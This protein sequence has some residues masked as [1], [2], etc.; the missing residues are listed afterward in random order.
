MVNFLLLGSESGYIKGVGLQSH[1]QIF[2]Y[3]CESAANCCSFIS[4]SSV[5]FGTK[6]GKVW[7]F[8]LQA[9]QPV[10]I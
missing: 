4:S 6:D 8:D 10:T 7:L 9:R 5:A 1:K 3:Q 2:Q